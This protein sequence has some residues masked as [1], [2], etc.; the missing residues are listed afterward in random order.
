MIEEKIV[1]GIAAACSTFAI[2]ACLVTIPSL[3]NTIN[4]IHDEV[5]DGVQVSVTIRYLF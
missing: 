5:V 3:Y 1:I 4:D 2:L